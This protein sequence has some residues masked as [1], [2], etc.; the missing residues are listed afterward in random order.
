M[1]V[2]FTG[3]VFVCKCAFD[4][5]HLPK[6][7][8]FRW[9]PDHKIWYTPQPGVAARLRQYCDPAAEKELNRK[10]IAIEPWAGGLVYP[11]KEV[12]RGFQIEAATF[13]LSRNSSYLALD[14]G[15]GKAVIACV[16]ANT[17]NKKSPTGIVYIC[18]PFLT[19][20]MEVEFKRW[21]DE[22]FVMRYTCHDLA[23]VLIVPDS[24][25]TRE[26]TQLDIAKFTAYCRERKLSSLLIVD[27]AHRFKNDEAGRTRALFGHHPPGK[28]R[29]KGMVERF[30]RVIYLSGTPM[31]NRPIELYPVLNASAPET[32]GFMSKHQ[33]ASKY[34]GAFQ[35]QW[36]WDY[37]GATNVTELASQVIG[38]F[39]LRMKKADVLAE[40]PPKTEEL[41]LIGDDLNPKLAA[42]DKRILENF[43]PEDLTKGQIAIET[44]M[45]DDLHLATYRREL[46]LLKSK[47][48]VK[49]IKSL[50]EE[51]EESLLIFGIHTDV[52][53]HLEKE[54]E[55][56]LPLVITGQTPMAAR[57]EIVKTF[58]S[59]PSR[60]VFI[61]NIQAAGTGL[62]LTKATRVIFVEFSWVP[63][64][65]EQASDRAHRIGQKD[66][67]FVQ[68]LVY[69][70][71]IDRAVIET[72][73]R[74][75][76]ITER[77][78]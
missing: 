22:L 74:K 60:R 17:L 14:P 41:V 21:A 4:T 57:H 2:T 45:G 49:Y 35:N 30:D 20:N 36:G 6:E 27:E 46:G 73:L 70:N 62:T 13:S 18:P 16:V 71:S 66:N 38:K 50:L 40:L 37:S 68:Y 69:K 10:L 76:S 54:L 3:D 12:L 61:G 42:L 75:K 25:I 34:C 26:Q 47:E 29:L 28:A 64:D 59:D 67:V 78:V 51:S 39:M 23:Q 48:A 52:I 33:Y 58:Q 44:K 9:S 8:G 15:L 72:V 24:I 53:G 11:P 65:N 19:R 32:I 55:S 7:A 31:P 77:L 1:K 43:S 56:Y 5:R 63:S